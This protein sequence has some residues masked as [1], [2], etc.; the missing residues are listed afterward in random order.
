MSAFVFCARAV[1]ARAI[2][3]MIGIDRQAVEADATRVA[4][5]L[6]L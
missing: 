1:S 5:L 2:E 6:D 4:A 3:R